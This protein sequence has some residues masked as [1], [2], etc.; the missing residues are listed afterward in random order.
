MTP[1][2]AFTPPPPARRHREDTTALPISSEWH[3]EM[4]DDSGERHTFT[5]LRDDSA[6][7]TSRHPFSLIDH[8]GTVSSVRLLEASN[9][10]FVALVLPRSRNPE[11]SDE[12]IVLE[13]VRL[14]DQIAGRFVSRSHGWRNVIRSGEFS[15]VL[16]GTTVRAA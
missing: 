6:A 1:R 2:F 13:G 15:A 16:A 3:G 12:I 4:V 14:G 5:L 10:A 9:R 7:A 8:T 11:T